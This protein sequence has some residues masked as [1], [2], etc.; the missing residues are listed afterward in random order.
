MTFDPK[1]LG[2]GNKGHQPLLFGQAT[3]GGERSNARSQLVRAF[4]N[5]V[6][7]GLKNTHGGSNVSPALYKNNVLGPFRTAINGGDVVTRN[8]STTNKKY[9]RE[10][11]QVNGNNV[12][13][14]NANYGGIDRS[15]EAMYAGN[16]KY[17]YD[18]SDY[19]RFRKLQAIN[20]TFNDKSYGGAENNQT[21]SIL[22]H[23]RS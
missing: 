12:S 20:R 23:V 17:I 6:I 14:I 16:P 5:Q 19:T 21:Q 8:I 22:R 11:N 7:P 18:G 4:G 1:K 2:Q 3:G 13:R 10:S 15:G 9:G